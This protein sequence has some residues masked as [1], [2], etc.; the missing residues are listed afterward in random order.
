LL[1]GEELSQYEQWLAESRQ[2]VTPP[3]PTE[4]QEAYIVESRR[5]QDEAEIKRV[6]RERLVRRFRTA[7]VVLGGFFLLAVIAT[8]LTISITNRAVNAANAQVAAGNTQ[9]AVIGQTLTPIPPQLTAVARTIVAGSYM[10]ES[11]NL[12]AE[13]NS[14]LR[15]GGGNAETA[16]LLSIRVLRKIYLDSADAALVDATS[17]LKAVPQVFA[18]QSPE[19]SVA[20]S[21]DGKTF[22]I[23]NLGNAESSTVELRDTASGSVIWTDTIKASGIF[24]VA[25]SPDGKLVVVAAGDHTARILEAASGNSIRVLEGHGDVVERAVFSPDGKTVLTLVGGSD[26]TVHL[27]IL[28]TG[29]QVFSVPAGV[30]ASS[31][32]FLPDGQTF[33]A[34]DNLYN[35]SDGLQIQ[36]KGLGGGTLII[37][38]NGRTYLSGF[39]PTPELHDSNS[40]QLLR[41]FSGHS[42][43]VVSAAFSSDGKWLVTGSKDN[44]ARVWEVA[45]GKQVL[46]LSGNNTQVNSVAFSPDGTRV[47]TGSNTV[48][49]WN[50]SID[51]QQI[52]FTTPAGITTSALAPDGKTILVGDED[53]NT[54]LWDLNTGKLLRNFPRDS[55]DVKSVAISPDGKVAALSLRSGPNS[56]DVNLYDLSTGAL[57]NTFP[58]DT[59]LQPFIGSLSFSSD[60]KM[61]LVGYFDNIARLWD[62]SSGQELRLING[63]DN[64][65]FSGVLTLSPDGDLVVLDGGQIW[66]NIST[67]TRG[68][69]PDAM[70]GDKV[71]FSAD[72]SLVAIANFNRSVSVW[73]VASQQLVNSFSGHSD[74][75][76]SLA[77]SPDDRLLVTGSAD[78]TAQVWDIASGQMLRVLT[79]H[80]AAVTSV[81]F[82][83]DGKKIVTTSLDMTVRTWIS[84]YN[85]LLAYACT[86]VGVDLTQE[87]RVLYGV[88][89]QDPTCPQFGEQSQSLLPTTTPVPTFTPLP[90]WTPIATPTQFT[91]TP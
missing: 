47:L 59:S 86:L 17:R 79:G 87:E 56:V 78:K 9:V 33:Y 69:F 30:G 23:G 82:T 53:G 76:T 55:H 20:F 34:N 31:L 15:T 27:F 68:S 90:P 39:R 80:S 13:A 60:S 8:V 25:F 42:D 66:W 3:H 24:S 48:R 67:G 14:I 77:F 2:K 4:E 71:V 52:T 10:I 88:S 70:S 6:Q 26:R 5:V 73:D 41:S 61:L 1:R 65:N 18:T 19:S 44:T 32:F 51:K 84:D 74:V 12:S 63:N 22:L 38:P 75:V 50:I 35:A 28:E 7:S 91:P 37:S 16:A 40:G 29:K 81:A 45:S 83:P 85:D 64:S 46:L 57:L 58:N 49:L 89:D 43:L 21:P 11:L 54:G 72:G 36:D 62:V